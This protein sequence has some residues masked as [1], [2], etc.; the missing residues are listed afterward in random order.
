V[1]EALVALLERAN[2]RRRVRLLTVADVHATAREALA[3]AHGIA[4]GHGGGGRNIVGM[5]TLCLAVRVG[6]SKVVVG[7]RRAFADRPSPGSVWKDLAPWHQDFARNVDKARRWAKQRAADRLVLDVEAAGGTSVERPAA[8]SEG[9]L[10]AAVLADPSDDEARLVYADF[11]SQSDD[12]R[13]EL[14]AV[15]CALPTAPKN[16]RAALAKREKELLKAHARAWTKH[17][18]QVALECRFVR[19]FVGSITATANA[20]VNHGAKLWDTD[21]LEELV[22][23]K[24]TAPGLL[25][26]AAAPHV[27]RLQSF[28]FSSP[29]FAE[30]DADVTAARRFFA[31]PHVGK[32]RRMTLVIH[33]AAPSRDMLLDELALPS[34]E[35]LELRLTGSSGAPA[36]LARAKLPA[37]RRL[38]VP[39][40]WHGTLRE[41]FPGAE[42]TSKADKVE[43]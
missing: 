41:A 15:Q 40:A 24:P 13:G 12:P 10:L 28:C 18:S 43:R 16:K 35:V 42:I 5:T 2:Q 20:F 9:A 37:L 36:A 38:V 26:I 33:A 23:S 29:F 34:M 3:S 21:P 4:V 1:N 32:L 31:S 30:R 8:R 19:G 27:A 7:L 6:S 22:L 17:A 39:R 25:A 14:I 11:L